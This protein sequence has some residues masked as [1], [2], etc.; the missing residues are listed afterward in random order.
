M[1]C[2][3]NKREVIRKRVRRVR[4]VKREQGFRPV[5]V[6]ISAEAFLMLQALSKKL[7]MRRRTSTVI[8][9]A[10]KSFYADLNNKNNQL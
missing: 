3:A 10:I 4:E 5:S 1:K 2:N 7:N 6:W 9:K 8:E